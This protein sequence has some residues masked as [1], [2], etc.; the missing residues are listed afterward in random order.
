M[1]A[2]IAGVI[3]I[4]SFKDKQDVALRAFLNGQGTFCSLQQ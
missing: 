3:G 2:D 1:L 4:I